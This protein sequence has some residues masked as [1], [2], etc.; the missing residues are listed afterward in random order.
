MNQTRSTK[1][2]KKED[3]VEFFNLIQQLHLNGQEKK[4]LV[5]FL[6]QL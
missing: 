6:R 2:K 3:A 4:D 5:A 1:V